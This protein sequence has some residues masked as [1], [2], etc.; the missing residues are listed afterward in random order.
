MNFS[1]DLNGLIAVGQRCD[2][3]GWLPGGGGN[4]SL[5][6][7]EGFWI[8]VSG[9][10]KGFLRAPDFL[11]C[12]PQGGAAGKPSAEMPLHRL[13]YQQTAAQCVLHVHSPAATVASLFFSEQVV[14]ADLELLK[15]FTGISDHATPRALAIFPNDQDMERLALSIAKVWSSL[16]LPA[17]LIRGHGFYTWGNHVEATLFQVE[18]LEFMLQVLLQLRQLTPLPPPLR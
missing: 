11:H 15:A 3:K 7:L 17:F 18:A 12:D 9:R 16:E 8:T 4:F 1:N 5:R 13:V 14:L 10:H 2:A 6:S